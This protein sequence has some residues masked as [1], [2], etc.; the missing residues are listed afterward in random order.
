MHRQF[1][2]FDLLRLTTV[3]VVIYDTQLLH[4]TSAIVFSWYEQHIQSWGSYFMKVIYYTRM[5]K[6]L[7]I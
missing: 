2:S 1:L 5:I 7:K 4:F 3:E 6:K